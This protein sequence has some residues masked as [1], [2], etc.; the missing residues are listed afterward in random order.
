MPDI[1]FRVTSGPFAGAYR[2]SPS[3][4]TASDVGDLLAQG[5]PDL[6]AIL[7]GDG[8]KGA[9]MFAGL[10]WLVRRRGS[11]KGLAFRAVSDAINFD[12]VEPIGDDEEES[13]EK[14]E[15]PSHSEGG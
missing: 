4:I 15:D 9:R 13:A 6:D 5:G 3:D 2:V 10:A 1:T 11:S 7:L 8:P 14:L 12:I